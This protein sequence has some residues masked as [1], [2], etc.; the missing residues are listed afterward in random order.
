MAGLDKAAAAAALDLHEDMEI[1]TVV[2]IGKLAPADKLEG[3]LHEREIA[4]RTRV[5]LADI[6][7]HG[8]PA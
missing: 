1:I 7:L 2:A 8:L 3:P 5:D 4:P 6:V